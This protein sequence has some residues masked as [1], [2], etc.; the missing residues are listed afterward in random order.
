MFH[1]YNSVIITNGHTNLRL[2]YCLMIIFKHFLNFSDVVV[3]PYNSLLTLKRLT[4]CAD[5]VV[6]LDNT[7]LNRIATDRLHLE[8][9][10]HNTTKFTYN[11]MCRPKVWRNTIPN[12]KSVLKLDDPNN[13]NCF[14]PGE[15]EISW[16]NQKNHNWK[17]IWMILSH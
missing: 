10:I 2:I 15:A 17:F 4:N 8:V 7:A 5:C 3:Q 6:V 12:R 11:R 1:T 16:K 9:C 14:F 13:F